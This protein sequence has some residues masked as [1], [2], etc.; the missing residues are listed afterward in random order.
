MLTREV[1]QK[2]L[3]EKLGH[4]KFSRQGLKFNCP[5]CDAGD[6]YNLEVNIDRNI[7]NCWSCRYSGILRRLFSNYAVDRSWKQ[8]PELKYEK[9]EEEEQTKT[10]NYPTNTIA[11]Y[12]HGEAVD[13]LINQR[14]V[15]RSVLI[16]R[17]VEYSYSNEDT[18]FNHICFPFYENGRM[19]G[20]C[21]Q[22]LETKAYRNL[23]KLNFVAYKE[24][25]NP[26]YPITI[27]EGAYDALVSIN[28]TP[29]LS[30]EV[31]KELLEFIS[32]K[33]V[34]LALDNT[35]ELE[36]YTRQVKR[37]MDAGVR[38]LIL[39]DLY[40]YK[41]MNSFYL[42]DKK[43]FIDEYNQCFKKILE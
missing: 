12:S 9:K 7:F 26:L 41:D 22:N 6:K 5:K 15:D 13:Y 29:L 39:F 1:I 43:K 16:E 25:I 21:I 30:T 17:G 11:F 36:Q 14:G 37:I 3:E 18:Y 35:I 19:V 2:Y 27:T 31:S 8:I 33:D 4:A 23:G 38:K 28:A 32:G 40:D 42:G 34:I 24:F 20:A 10:L